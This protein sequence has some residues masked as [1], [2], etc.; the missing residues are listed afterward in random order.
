M[1]CGAA[2]AALAPTGMRVA[3]EM[4]LE[5][6]VESLYLHRDLHRSEVILNPA[7]SPHQ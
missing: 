4:G 2:F 7:P 3:A 6:S 1:A 5:A